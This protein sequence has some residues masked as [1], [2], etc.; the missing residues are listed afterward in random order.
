VAAL[1]H[2]FQV[3]FAAILGRVVQVRDGQ[4]NEAARDRVRLMVDGSAA[5][6]AFAGV[7]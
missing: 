1:A 7:V 2:G 6:L 5:Q 4:D 3:R